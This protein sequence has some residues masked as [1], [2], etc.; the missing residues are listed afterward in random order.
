MTRV[1][2]W[3]LL[4]RNKSWTYPFENRKNISC[5]AVSPNDLLMIS[6]DEGTASSVCVASRADNGALLSALDSIDDV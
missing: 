4:C 2:T 6:V 5:F 1:V 3:G